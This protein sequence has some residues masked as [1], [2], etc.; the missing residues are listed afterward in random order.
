MIQFVGRGG[1]WPWWTYTI[2]RLPC[3]FLKK[4]LP[5]TEFLKHMRAG[6]YIVDLERRSIFLFLSGELEVGGRGFNCW[7]CWVMDCN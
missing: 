3:F 5:R 4:K 1:A 6:V 7:C 2:T